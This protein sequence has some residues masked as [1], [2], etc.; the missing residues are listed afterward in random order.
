[1]SAIV[2]GHLVPCFIALYAIFVLL[3]LIHMYISFILSK[4]GR[5]ENEHFTW[6]TDMSFNP[7]LMHP[8]LIRVI[9]PEMTISLSDVCHEVT[10]NPLAMCSDV[11]EC[12]SFDFQS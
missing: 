11:C 10:V 2:A 12:E 3:W 7:V 6:S 1:M 8:L 4:G 5:Y 9:C